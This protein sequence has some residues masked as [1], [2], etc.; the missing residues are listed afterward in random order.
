[1]KVV[2]YVRIRT[3]RQ[4]EQGVGLQEQERSIHDWAKAHEH[5]LVEVFEDS[6]ESRADGL[7]TRVGLG[8]ALA[9]LRTGRAGG[10]VVYRLDRLARDVILQEA[11]LNEICRHRGQLFSTIEAEAKYLL[12]DPEDPSRKLIR[13][14]LGAI[15]DY[16]RAMIGLRLMSGR[17]AKATRGGYAYGAPPYGYVASNKRLV[18]EPREQEA[19]KLMSVLRKRGSSLPKICSEL[20]EAGFKPR[21]GGRWYP[22]SVS[23]CLNRSKRPH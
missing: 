21:R 12:N 9:A 10:L 20:E 19:L 8:E 7:E 15:A 2:G 3:D 17:R 18:P 23:R 5:R 11:L 22:T 13:Q 6:G 14:V 4:V 16:E 1:M